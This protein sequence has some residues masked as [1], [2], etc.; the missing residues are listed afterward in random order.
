VFI[1][2]G[3]AT[4]IGTDPCDRLLYHVDSERRTVWQFDLDAA[5]LAGSR[6]FMVA[7]PGPP[8]E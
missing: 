8:S 4:G 2:N 3:I 7:E 6:Q 1:S 5:D